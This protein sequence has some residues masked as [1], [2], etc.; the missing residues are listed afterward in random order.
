M[1]LEA[2]YVAI[3]VMALITFLTRVFPFI[4]FHNGKPPQV[5]LFI[6]RYIPRVMMAILVVYCLKDAS[7]GT[8]PY[9][10]NELL[11]VGTVVVLHLWRR[12]ALVSIFGATLLYMFLVQ[13]SVLASWL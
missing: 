6:G 11:A 5:V 4:F 7:W 8:A 10:L 1:K 2:V 9:G 12:N 3:F 13:S